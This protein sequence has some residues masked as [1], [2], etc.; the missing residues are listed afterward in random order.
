V[1]E[2]IL[3]RHGQ[4]SL[5]TDDYDRLSELGVGQSRALGSA[6]LEEELSPDIAWSGTLKRQIDTAAAVGDV[7]AKAGRSWPDVQLHD[8]LNEYPGEEIVTTLGRHL[9][10]TDPAIAALADA[11]ESSNAYA[12]RY[13]HLHRLLEAVIARWVAGDYEPSQVPVTWR[14]WSEAVRGALA[15]I[16]M[17]AGSG[18]RVAVFTSGGPIAVSVQTVL[19]APDIKAAEL[20]WR[21]NNCSV[22]RYTWSGERISLDRFN[23]IAHLPRNMRTFR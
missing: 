20:N 5:F 6:W 19:S 22:T 1:S 2:L 11:Y 17:T 3:V 21:I 4:A 8:G 15:D 7:F 23:D 12:D 16:M 18:R 14:D 13:R 9:R 10:G